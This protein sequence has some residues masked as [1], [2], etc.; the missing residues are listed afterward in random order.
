MKILL[1]QLSGAGDVLQT[2]LLLRCLKKSRPDAEI[3]LLVQQQHADII[4]NNKNIDQLHRLHFNRQTT[5]HELLPQHFDHVLDLQPCRE[6][7]LYAEGLK[8]EEPALKQKGFKTFFT[9]WWNRKP[10]PQ[11]KA[12]AYL[13][14]ASFLNVQHDGGGLDMYVPKKEEVPFGDIPASHHAGF[15]AI[16][17]E[18]TNHFQWPLHLLQQI[19]TTIQHPIVLVGTK[20]E[21]PLAQKAASFDNIK[22][23]N[24]CGKFSHFETADLVRKAKLL[25]AFQPYYRQLGAAFSKEMVMLA[26]SNKEDAPYYPAY[27]LKSKAGSPFDRINLP[28]MLLQQETNTADE[29]T[30]LDMEKTAGEIWTKTAHRLKGKA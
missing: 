27:F 13:Q 1:I 20:R 14:K 29:K 9:K 7:A 28:K 15:I 19:C 6:S 5:L 8:P 21:D 22:I 23:Y 12:E 18:S 17:L 30:R 10:V 3:H 11:Y 16:A 2:T 26:T 24:A 4:S 25:I